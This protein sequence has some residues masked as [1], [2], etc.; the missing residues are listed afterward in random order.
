MMEVLNARDYYGK[1]AIGTVLLL[2]GYPRHFT[3]ERHRS[4]ANAAA[5]RIRER[6]LRDG[7]E[8]PAMTPGL[9]AAIS[10]LFD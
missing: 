10:K 1:H 5:A 9:F 3:G 2:N 6:A 4:E 7:R 8:P